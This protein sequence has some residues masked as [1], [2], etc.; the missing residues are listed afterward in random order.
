MW[1]RTGSGKTLIAAMVIKTLQE[2]DKNAVQTVSNTASSAVATND[3]FSLSSL[4]PSSSSLL[5]SSSKGTLDQESIRLDMTSF[6]PMGKYIFLAPQ[7]SLTE[8]QSQVLRK[9]VHGEVGCYY[10]NMSI[11][12]WNKVKWIKEYNSY[13]VLVMTPSIFLE[14]LRRAYVD[15]KDIRLI[16]FDE[17]HHA[18]KSHPFNCIM[19]EFYFLAK[20]RPKILGLTACPTTGGLKA[21]G[22]NGQINEQLNELEY[23]LDSKIVRRN[24]SSIDRDYCCLPN[25][26][27][28]YFSDPTIREEI[29]SREF[30]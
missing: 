9:F 24:T 17:C 6:S 21:H 27:V 1:M 2:N 7:M 4:P 25:E 22:S 23:N 15:M 29:V 30:T 19:R 8:Q 16:V 5:S 20:N 14:H 12:C 18:R 26:K 28:I 10:G 11:E 13:D 3:N